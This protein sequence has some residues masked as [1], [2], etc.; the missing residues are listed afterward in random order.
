MNARRV[1]EEIFPELAESEDERI[2]KRI[3]LCLEECVHGDIIRD[4]EAES[5]ITWLEKQIEQKPG[6]I[7]REWYNKGYLEGRKNAHIPARELG[8]PKKYD[9][10]N[11]QKPAEKQD[12]SGLSDLERAIHRGFLVAGVENVP[13]T[14]IKE[15]AQ[16]CQR[17][18]KP[19]EWSEGDEAFIDLLI[20][21]L[22]TEHPNGLF[23]MSPEQ[24]AA[25]KCELMPVN[26][27]IDWLK[28]LRPQPH[29]KPS[30]EQMAGLCR[31]ILNTSEG[32]DAREALES[33]YADLKKL[34]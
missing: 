17:R 10:F 5:A 25:L 22:N 20:G 30:E 15:T 19:A 11:E 18:I 3:K 34:M 1:V 33:L 26:R 16:E 12:Y 32:S 21:I 24:S 4:Y 6:D 9:V 13:V 7:E 14:I 23:T 29:W 31:G 27:I 8:L 2:R 28:S